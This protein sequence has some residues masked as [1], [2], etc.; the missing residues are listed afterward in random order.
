MY[1]WLHFPIQQR[2]ILNH[3]PNN[4]L[5]LDKRKKLSRKF[6]T[7]LCGIRLV[8]SKKR[9]RN[10][11]LA[12]LLANALPHQ[13][14]PLSVRFFQRHHRFNDGCLGR[15]RRDPFGKPKFSARTGRNVQAVLKMCP[16]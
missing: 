6:L 4:Q 7:A 3:L 9:E 16:V 8:T 14:S 15:V 5:S 1:P 13:F 10:R 11:K 12:G 2:L